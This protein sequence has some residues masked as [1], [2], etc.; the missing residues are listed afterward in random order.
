SSSKDSG[1]AS[2]GSALPGMGSGSTESSSSSSSLK[3][4]ASSSVDIEDVHKQNKQIIK[5]LEEIKS[6]VGGSSNELL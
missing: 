6:E 5:L 1:S 4:T 2:D 3:S